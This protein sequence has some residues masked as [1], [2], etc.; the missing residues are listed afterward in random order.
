[1]GIAV[2]E[3]LGLDGVVAKRLPGFE[4]RP[5]QVAMASA[6]ERA[7]HHRQHLAVEAGTGVGKSFAYLIPAIFRAAEN[8]Q[9][10]VISTHTIALQ[11]QLIQKDLPFLNAVLPVEFS[12]VLLKGRSNYLGLRRLEQTSKKQQALIQQGEL[13]ELW[14]VEDWAYVTQDGSLSDLSPMPLP[15]VWE[16]V[17]SQH[18]NCMGRR[19]RNYEKCFYQRAK[20]RARHAQLIVVNHA[21][22]FADLAL[23]QRGSSVLPP[24]DIVVI[25][26]AHTMDRVG[27]EHFGVTVS[28]SQVRFL[29]SS[30]FHGKTQRGLLAAC[31]AD[32]AIAAVIA[33][34][35]ATNGFFKALLNWHHEVGPRNGRIR[36]PHPVVN[37]LSPALRHLAGR[38]KALRS[39]LGEEE[40]QFEVNAQME[41]AEIFADLIDEIMSQERADS[42]YW[43]EIANRARPRVTLH[44]APVDI[45]QALHEVLFSRADSAILTSATLSTGSSDDFEYLRGRLGFGDVETL[46]LGSPFN[47]KKQVKVHLASGM[48]DPSEGEAYHVAV[49]EKIRQYVDMTE[50]KAFVLFTS[51]QMMHRL[52]DELASWFDDRGMALFVQGRGMDRS[53][54]LARFREDVN[55]VIFGTNSFWQGVDVA[56]ESLSNVIIV[57]LPFEVPDRPF[58]EARSEHIKAL[59]GDPFKDYQLPEAVLKFK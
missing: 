16:R 39:Q 37:E 19:C 35:A 40:E 33:A 43:M 56:G 46:K 52:A 51:Y 27:C 9:R 38:L 4:L 23:K 42:V 26:E 25:D 44:S 49:R 12:A 30:L 45:S 55:S 5:E 47:Y 2:S 48:P 17:N 58:V 50:G 11:E 13:D 36:T 28:D 31:H 54:M 15:Q 24:Y 14:R 6:V 20:R 8:N 18:G 41:R 57:K 10:V 59:G 3:T 53:E 29:L 22:L 21:L 7:F 32:A 34:R 1:M